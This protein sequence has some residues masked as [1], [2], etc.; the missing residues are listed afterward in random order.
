M[1]QCKIEW[2][3]PAKGV[4]T[5]PPADTVALAVDVGGNVGAIRIFETSSKKYVDGVGTEEAGKPIM[6][7]W[8]SAWYYS[9]AGS[10]PLGYIAEAK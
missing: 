8:N 5:S 4:R 10:L 6:I 2:I 7:S 1:W 9:A 3:T